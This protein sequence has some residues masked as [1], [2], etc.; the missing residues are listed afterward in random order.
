MRS[1]KVPERFSLDSQAE[2]LYRPAVFNGFAVSGRRRHKPR[3]AGL[4]LFLP[5]RLEFLV[6]NE[7][8]KVGIFVEMRCRDCAAGNRMR[9]TRIST[10]GSPRTRLERAKV[11]DDCVKTHVLIPKT[12]GKLSM[13]DAKLSR[14]RTEHKPI[15]Q[16]SRPLSVWDRNCGSNRKLVVKSRGRSRNRDIFHCIR[17][18]PPR[19]LSEILSIVTY[20]RGLLDSY[21]D[22]KGKPMSPVSIWYS[23]RSALV[24]CRVMAGGAR[25]PLATRTCH[26][27]R[28]GRSFGNQ[29]ARRNAVPSMMFDYIIV[30]GGSAGSV[31]ANRLSARSQNKV[32]LLEAGQDTPHGKVPAAVLDSYPGT[33]YLNPNYTWNKLKVTTEVIS[34]N[35]PDEKAPPL[36]TY[37]QARILGGGSSING[38]LANRGAPTDYDE[39]AAQRRDRLG[40]EQRAALL[41]E[42]RARHGL[43]WSVAR[44]G[45]PHPGPPHLSRSVA[46]TRQGGGQGV[47]AGRLQVHP[48]PERANGRTGI[49]RSPSPTPMNAG[50]RRRSA[51]SIPA[52]GCGK[53]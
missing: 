33:A 15:A 36:R 20:S 18:C 3:Q 11:G 45:G 9:P 28:S 34:H 10:S 8:K 44:Q 2:T 39:W 25:R 30:G 29:E 27:C 41:Q 42:G 14:A 35:N 26:T 23:T 49:S 38:Q 4:R 47:R 6:C 43:R 53:T 40:L 13:A 31:L 7:N 19:R 22:F 16:R 5:P 51:T 1:N 24:R 12:R 37:E 48:G 52:R 17:Q 50:C 46:R 21:S 32:L